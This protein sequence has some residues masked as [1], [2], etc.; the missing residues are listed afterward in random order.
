MK[1]LKIRKKEEGLGSAGTGTESGQDLVVALELSVEG[2]VEFAA[3]AEVDGGVEAFATSP[4]VALVVSLLDLV[5]DEVEAGT[6]TLVDVG[7]EDGVR[8]RAHDVTVLA[9]LTVV[10]FLKGG[11]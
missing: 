3:D 5:G 4:D 8:L 10:V 7:D 1:L 9:L 11:W 6:V 2:I